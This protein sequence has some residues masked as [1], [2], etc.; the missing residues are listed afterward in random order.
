VLIADKF[1]KLK[2]EI[3]FWK[4]YMDAEVFKV[5]SAKTQVL[6]SGSV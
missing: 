2:E 1:D 5:T 6:V 3:H 4:E